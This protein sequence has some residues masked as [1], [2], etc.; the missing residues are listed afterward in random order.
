M[1]QH[2]LH[3]ILIKQGLF[4][5]FM[6]LC[7]ECLDEKLWV[8]GCAFSLPGSGSA[9]CWQSLWWCFQDLL[10]KDE[11]VCAQV[12]AARLTDPGWLLTLVA[13]EE[14]SF[15]CCSLCLAQLRYPIARLP[16]ALIC[17]TAARPS[18]P[19]SCACRCQP[20]WVPCLGSKTR[21]SW[22]CTAADWAEWIQGSL[23]GLWDLCGQCLLCQQNYRIP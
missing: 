15:L 16:P 18:C 8:G 20:A 4:W 19:G 11:Q 7:P 1:V 9:G 22:C 13:R 23:G 17:V 2:V 10:H 14:V 3:S 5:L 12:N 21:R 6:L